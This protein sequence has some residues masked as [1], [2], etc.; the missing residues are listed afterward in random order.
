MGM[1]LHR[2]S[3]EKVETPKVVEKP[4]IKND[5]IEKKVKKPTKTNK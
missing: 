4:I 1:I 3:N 5:E 2:H